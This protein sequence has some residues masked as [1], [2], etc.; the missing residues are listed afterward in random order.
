MR[1]NLTAIISAA[2]LACSPSKPDR[3]APDTLASAR[4]DS[5][6]PL[7]SPAGF[8]QPEAVRYD[9]DQ[10]IYFVSNWGNG[11]PEAK[12]N[13]GFISRMTPDGTVERPRFIAGGTGGATLHAPRGMT[14][15]GDT[16]WVVDADAV[17]GFNRRTGAPLATANFSA[18]KLG[19]LNDIAA[20]PDALYVTDTGTDHIYRIAGGRVTVAVENTALG[21]PNGITWDAGGHR[22]II[23]PWAGDSTIK[24]WTPGT[25]TLTVV[26]KKGSTR[27]DGVEILPGD[28]VLVSAQ[29]DSSLYIFTG[30]TG[31]SIIRTGG[32]PADI[33]VDTKRNRVAVPFVDRNMVEIWE[34]PAQ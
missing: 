2:V 28:R 31:R 20:G 29:G 8:N 22:M 10:D 23:V 15:V 27:Y 25:K 4:P 26:G 34:L 11:G 13:N 33:A 19:F 6:R 18:F 17:R 9:P 30:G 16:L 32:A 5:A 14:I 1:S 7:A 24:A 12:D 21:S 3:A